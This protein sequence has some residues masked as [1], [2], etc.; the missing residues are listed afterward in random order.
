MKNLVVHPGK[1]YLMTEDGEPFFYLGDTA[2]EMFHRLSRA[3]IDYFLSLRAQQGFNVIQA[4]ALAELDGLRTPNV[5]G[6]VPLKQREGNFDPTLPD[7]DGEYSYWD[8]VDYGVRLAAEKGLY[9]ALLPTWGDKYNQKWGVGPEIFTPENARAYG[10]WIGERYR[11]D[12]NIIWM[13]GGDRQLET[14]AH[15]A[16]IDAMAEGLREGDGGRH[17]ITFHP[18]GEH[19]SN[20]FVGGKAYI[21]FHTAQSSHGT[22]GYQSWRMMRMM[23]EAEEKPFMDAEPRYEEMPAFINPSFGY[24]WDGDDVRQNTYW[25]LME[26]VCGNTY[27]NH[28]V[29][30]FRREI[31]EGWNYRWEQV[32][33]HPGAAEAQYA[34]ALRLSRPYFEFRSAP[35]LVQ[36]DPAAT[37]HQCAGR[38]EK[39]AFFYSPLGLP[40]R[41]YLDRLAPAGATI[42]ASW[43]DPR[44]GKMELFAVVPAKEALFVPPTS[45]KGCD[46][47]LVAD[48]A[49]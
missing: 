34:K 40:I 15:C 9:I 18:W 27:G 4:V 26:G 24:F 23:R 17:L 35:E 7:L 6:R 16:I 8:H 43:F 11:G 32:L 21:D 31:G 10:R 2:W 37:A 28:S 36:D 22:S 47:V 49:E 19:Y 46:W 45:G 48:V 33:H 13:L 1:R 29:W 44:T 42:K 25:N 14:D 5:Y 20:E 38:G 30:P 12:A 3:E 39:Y 41:A